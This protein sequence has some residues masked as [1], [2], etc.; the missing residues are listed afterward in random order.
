MVK[1]S[2]PIVVTPSGIVTLSNDEQPSKHW[3]GIAVT[4]DGILIVFNN[5]Q[6]LKAL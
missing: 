6:A 5:L 2:Q 4:P 3:S 1:A